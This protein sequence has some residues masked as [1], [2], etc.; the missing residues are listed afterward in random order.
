MQDI[1]NSIKKF[2]QDNNFQ[3]LT[4]LQNKQGFDI[5]KGFHEAF[6]DYKKEVEKAERNYFDFF[7]GNGFN[8]IQP[9]YLRLMF[10]VVWFLEIISQMKKHFLLQ[11]TT[12]DHTDFSNYL[13]DICD[14]QIA[15]NNFINSNRQNFDLYNAYFVKLEGAYGFN[16][17]VFITF[18]EF[19]DN[20]EEIKKNDYPY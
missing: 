9:E 19:K 15:C 1:I 8:K 18:K 7:N 16:G 12:Q 5:V 3:I 17:E 10:N 13:V 11:M 2:V 4:H 20:Y 14:T 6:L